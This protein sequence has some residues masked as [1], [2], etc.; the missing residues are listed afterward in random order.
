MKTLTLIFLFTSLV[1]GQIDTSKVYVWY[2]FSDETY[3]STTVKLLKDE[4]AYKFVNYWD[5]YS[6]EC[7][8]AEIRIDTTVKIIGWN[9]VE[10]SD[11]TIGGIARDIVLDLEYKTVK[12]WRDDYKSYG[13]NYVSYTLPPKIITVKKVYNIPN[14]SGFVEYLRKK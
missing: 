10:K 1:W 12:F 9:F 6:K 13:G 4:W 2:G 5:K 8:D 11:T 3:P 7:K 14:I